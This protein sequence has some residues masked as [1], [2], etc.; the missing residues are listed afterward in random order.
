MKRVGRRSR[1]VLATLRTRRAAADRREAGVGQRSSCFGSA[2]SLR[3][4]RWPRRSGGAAR[5]CYGATLHYTRSRGRRATD[6]PR[7]LLVL[8]PDSVAYRPVDTL[9]ARAASDEA[10][11]TS[12]LPGALVELLPTAARRASG[13]APHASV[14]RALHGLVDDRGRIGRHSRDALATLR[15]RRAAANRREAGVGQRSSCFGS[16]QPLRARR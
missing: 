11:A 6:G 7:A 2:R 16:A 13:G 4:R 15:L 5:D 8:W 1:D 12:S 9:D 14:R 3:A 10:H